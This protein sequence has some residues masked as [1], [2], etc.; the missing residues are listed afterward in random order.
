[1]LGLVVKS[2]H[3][4]AVVVVTLDVVVVLVLDIVVVL[5]LYDTDVVVLVLVF[6]DVVVVR[7]IDGG[8]ADVAVVIAAALLRHHLYFVANEIF[9]RCQANY[10]I[11][12]NIS[13]RCFFLSVKPIKKNQFRYLILNL[14]FKILRFST[15]R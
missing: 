8:D 7:G 3:D 2:F 6:G 9:K 4:V 10:V 1:M 11:L 13:L 5:V 14:F 12:D 15:I